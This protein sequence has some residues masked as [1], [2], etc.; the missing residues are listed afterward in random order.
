MA[1]KIHDVLAARRRRRLPDPATRRA[2][3]VAAGLSQA[4]VA[5]CVGV[6]RASVSRWETGH[7][8]PRGDTAEAYAALLRD[9]AAATASDRR[10][11]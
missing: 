11:D 2:L 9:L 7:R 6:D 5:A 3:R 1:T 8:S 10:W 4:D